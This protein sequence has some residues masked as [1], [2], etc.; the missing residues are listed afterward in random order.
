M[1]SGSCLEKLTVFCIFMQ[2]DVR[3]VLRI[4]V[5]KDAGCARC[6]RRGHRYTGLL[7]TFIYFSIIAREK[8][9]LEFPQLIDLLEERS[10]QH[11]VR[12]KSSWEVEEP[13]R[14]LL[15]QEPQGCLLA[16]MLK[17]NGIH[18]LINF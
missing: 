8:L 13:R 17:I 18:V 16:T 11:H 6:C 15:Q 9:N 2:H 3:P 4:I 5:A 12:S 10:K 7:E 1:L 14:G